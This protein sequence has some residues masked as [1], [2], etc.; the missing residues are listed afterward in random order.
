[1]AAGAGLGSRPG[2]CR[3]RLALG[4]GIALEELAQCR[5]AGELPEQEIVSPAA[6]DLLDDAW[7]SCVAGRPA[8]KLGLRPGAVSLSYDPSGGLVTT[9]EGR[10]RGIPFEP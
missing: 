6:D 1:M 9:T 2:R 3:G 5:G 10:S 4:P 8:D 7:G